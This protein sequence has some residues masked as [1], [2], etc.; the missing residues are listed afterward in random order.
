[1]IKVEAPSLYVRTSY[2][3]DEAAYSPSIVFEKIKCRYMGKLF[4]DTYYSI[5]SV[6][7]MEMSI[8]MDDEWHPVM[9]KRH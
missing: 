5:T 4:S 1:M 3:F 9:N 7:V 8:R 2:L 6:R